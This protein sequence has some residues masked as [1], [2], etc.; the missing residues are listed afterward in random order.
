MCRGRHDVCMADRS[1]VNA[2][3]HQAGDVGD[4]GEEYGVHLV[5]NL[6]ETSK[7]DTAGVRRRSA[8]DHLRP[9]FDGEATHF[10]VIDA[11]VF[12][13]YP[14]GDDVVELSRKVHRAAV[15]QVTAV[16]E[17]HC[18][19]RLAGL[20]HRLVD[21]SIRLRTGM[22]LDVGMIGPEELQ[23]ARH[24][25]VLGLVHDFAAPVVTAARLTLG[26]LVGQ[27]RTRGLEHRIGDEVL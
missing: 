22:R 3:R 17:V 21:R 11:L 15:G 4:V 25:E 9:M 23:R 27:H 2:G 1:C 16:V 10:V 20:K 14:V 26:V 5:R 6:P 19:N 18:E 12:P 13:A 8:L 24:R 7:I